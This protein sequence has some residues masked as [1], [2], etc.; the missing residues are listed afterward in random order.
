MRLNFKKIAAIG[1]GLL[2]TGMSMGLAAAAAFPAPFVVNGMPTNTAIVYGSNANPSD[3]AAAGTIQSSLQGA[4]VNSTSPSTS[5]VTVSGNAEALDQGGPSRIWMNTSLTTGKSIYTN[6]DLPTVLATSTFSGS[7]TAVVTQ[8]LTLGAG[9]GGTGT[10][11]DNSGRVI[12]DKMPTTSN[13]P[14][15]GVSIGTSVS[16]PLYNESVSFSQPINFASTQTQGQTISLFGNQYTVSSSSSATTGIVLYSSGIPPLNLAQGNSTTVT[17]N[18]QSYTITLGSVSTTQAVVSVNGVPSTLTSGGSAV[19]INGVNIGVTS[20]FPSSGISSGSATI[21]VGA[22]QLTFQNGAAVQVGTT[23][24]AIQ[25]TY[26]YLSGSVAACSGLTVAVFA[27]SSQQNA[28]IVKGQTF[29]DP[30]FGTFG[31]SNLGLSIPHFAPISNG[32]AGS[33]VNGASAGPGIDTIV[34]QPAGSTGMTL[35]FTDANNYSGNFVWMN[36]ASSSAYLGTPSYWIFPYEGA[37]ITQNNYTMTGTGSLGQLD[38]HLIQLT[39]VYNSSAG[40]SNYTLYNGISGN[41]YQND[42][43]QY[44]DVMSGQTWKSSTP[45]A[46]GVAPIIIDNR[47]YVVTFSSVGNL[48]WAELKYPSSDE[49]SQTAATSYVMYPAIRTAHGAQ[50]ELYQPLSFNITNSSFGLNT[51]T[52]SA[53]QFPNG[54]G[55]TSV[56]ITWVSTANAGN[57]TVGSSTTTQ[58]TFNASGTGAGVG[59][60]NVTIGQLKYNISITSGNITNVSLYVNGVNLTN[61]AVVVLEGKDISSNY[62]AIIIPENGA[63]GSGSAGDGVGTINLTSVTQF[64]AQSF[65]NTNL[66]G[67]VDYYGTLVVKN[68]ASSSQPTATVYYP[69]SQEYEQLYLGATS[70]SITVGSTGTGSTGSALQ[71]GKAIIPDTQVSSVYNDNLIVVGGS[72]VNAAAATLVGGAY[73]GS[74]WTTATGIGSGQ[75]LIESYN[76]TINAPGMT[77]LLVAGYNAADTQNAVVYL[78]TQK[79]DTSIGNKWTGSSTVSANLQVV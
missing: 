24:N 71:L 38:G 65:T 67:Y 22:N 7:S 66:Y 5:T 4:I 56:P 68:S 17:I 64:A 32:T 2:L 53:L 12:F 33:F 11:S 19:Q 13:D 57:W 79:P 63:A 3:S 39:Q 70:S 46:V 55:Y 27:P 58:T 59:Y 34:V 20:V 37:N 52:V 35:G 8:T 75:F 45:T 44:Y 47:Q 15:V 62:N 21:L 61:P 74:D 43:V 30:V 1:A 18:G 73:C 25:G 41:G 16:N 29:V 50:I 28:S 42:Y 14:A 76:S 40:Y 6:S 36:N 26:V 77:A 72:C 9:N 31:I 23:N 69:A 54:A 48:Q 49:G 60:A 51:Q 78:T 10:N